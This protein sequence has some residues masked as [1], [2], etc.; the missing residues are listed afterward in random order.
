MTLFPLAAVDIGNNRIKCGWF[1]EESTG[2]LPRAPPN[3]GA[4]R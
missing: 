3:D 1:M 2:A 4:C